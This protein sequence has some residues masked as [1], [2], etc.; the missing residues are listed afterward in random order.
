MPAA[1]NEV[2]LITKNAVPC[3][4]D[5]YLAQRRQNILQQ[6]KPYRQPQCALQRD[7]GKFPRL[8]DS[9]LSRHPGCASIAAYKY[10]AGI[11]PYA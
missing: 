5:R 6:A 7:R 11:D 2:E 4:L 8:C 3:M 10:F 9:R 1:H